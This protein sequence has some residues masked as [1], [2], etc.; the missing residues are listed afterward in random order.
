MKRDI[1]W[2]IIVGLLL[3]VI[4]QGV[5]W[6]MW[7][8]HHNEIESRVYTGRLYLVE[9]EYSQFKQ[10]LANH[11]EVIINKM[12]VMS[13]PDAV[14]D[15]IIKAPPETIVPYGKE[16]LYYHWDS[17]DIV[18]LSMASVFVMLAFILIYVSV[19]SDVSK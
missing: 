1:M 13:S 4:S 2:G 8:E 6:S 19:P 7:A 5:I 18:M 9:E 15:M 17:A 11:P 10:Y 14:I 12:D 3:L 16:K